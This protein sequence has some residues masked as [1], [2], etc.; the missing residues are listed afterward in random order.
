MRELIAQRDEAEHTL[1]EFRGNSEG[2]DMRARG[3]EDAQ[4]DLQ[5]QLVSAVA[6][7]QVSSC[8]YLLAFARLLSAA[9]P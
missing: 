4:R 6:V 1:F 3:L 9:N 8:R 2:K 5:Q 7:G